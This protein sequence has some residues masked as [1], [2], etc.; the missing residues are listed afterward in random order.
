MTSVAKALDDI[1]TTL[2]EGVE[3]VAV[4]KFHPAE[5]IRE[6]YDAGQRLFGESRTQELEG[7]QPSGPQQ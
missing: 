2:P 5:A 1:R 4:S 6:A 7:P 3:L